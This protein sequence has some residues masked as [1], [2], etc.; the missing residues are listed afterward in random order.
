M[1]LSPG[2]VLTLPPLGAAD[3]IRQGVSYRAATSTAVSHCTTA[4]FA[5]TGPE[6]CAKTVSIVNSVNTTIGASVVHSLVFA[7][8]LYYVAPLVGLMRLNQNDL[9]KMAV[10]F[11]VLTPGVLVTLPALGADECGKLGI[12]DTAGGALRTCETLM[13][14]LV[15]FSA[16]NTPKCHKCMSAWNSGF[17]GYLPISVHAALFFAILYMYTKK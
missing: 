1:L 3:G 6:I 10:L 12:A 4:D 2:L 15:T 8:L 11:F 14:D 7:V 13:D 5:S 17:T 9:V 16:A